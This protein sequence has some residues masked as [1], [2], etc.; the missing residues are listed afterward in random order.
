MVVEVPLEE[1]RTEPDMSTLNY[2]HEEVCLTDM[3]WTGIDT[4]VSTMDAYQQGICLISPDGKRTKIRNPKYTALRELKGMFLSSLRKRID[5][6]S[7]SCS[8][9]LGRQRDRFPNF[10]NILTRVV[11]I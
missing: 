4:Y 9:D 10:V 8:G 3:S 5:L 7:L 1:F 11:G 2:V 6:T